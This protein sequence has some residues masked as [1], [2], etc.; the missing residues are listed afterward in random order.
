MSIIDRKNTEQR[1]IY[2]FNDD[3]KKE[4]FQS[5]KEFKE[6]MLKF[7]NP[8]NDKYISDYQKLASGQYGTVKL[9]S[10]LKI[11]IKENKSF[12]EDI[13]EIFINQVRINS[14]IIQKNNP[15]LP[16]M[17]SY[18]ICNPNLSNTYSTSSQPYHISKTLK[19]CSDQ[20]INIKD[21]SI[22]QINDLLKNNY[23]KLYGLYEY[24][25]GKTL[26][27]YITS[28]K[29]IQLDEKDKWLFIKSV[30]IQIFS[31][32]D[33]ISQSGGYT[34]FDLHTNNI[35]IKDEQLT[36]TYTLSDG[37]EITV[38][39][40]Y[41]CFIIDQGLS[42]IEYDNKIFVYEESFQPFIHTADMFKIL[43]KLYLALST[44]DKNSVNTYYVTKLK[45]LLIAI[46]GESPND[47]TIIKYITKNPQ[48][49]VIL[50]MY[51]IRN[52]IIETIISKMSYK[53]FVL[54]I[55]DF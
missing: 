39:D 42:N 3:E 41:R 12:I 55:K 1:L 21:Y 34:H 46:F 22:S 7:I 47:D 43:S 14:E 44:F 40:P 10:L 31:S 24:I 54:L 4:G 49:D 19:L 9:A 17:I 38:D 20:V 23:L 35:I 50:Y 16:I 11:V 29:F 6:H 8:L 48:K 13:N 33:S 27:Q 53:D 15:N 36:H 25:E 28:L 51:H 45:E 5:S 26:G 30:L 52:E 32:L 37:S 18:I 2:L